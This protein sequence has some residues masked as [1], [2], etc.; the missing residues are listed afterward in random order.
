MNPFEA[1]LQEAQ[2]TE[3]RKCLLCISTLYSFNGYVA[4]QIQTHC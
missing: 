3:T 4:R 1:E 2:G